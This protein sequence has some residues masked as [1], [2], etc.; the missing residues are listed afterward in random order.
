MNV[1]RHIS[2]G[3]RI[4]ELMR[5]AAVVLGVAVAIGLALPSTIAH[6]A[7]GYDSVT[8]EVP[9][10]VD[11][12]GDA[13]ADAQT[14][15]FVMEPDDGETVSPDQSVVSVDGEGEATFSVS[16]DEVGEHHYTVRQ[17]AG[18]ADGWTYD[19]Q[20]YEVTVY[21]YDMGDQGAD[22]LRTLVIV[23]DGEGY[24]AESCA[25]TNAYE[26]A[27]ENVDEG[28]GGDA[29][30]EDGSTAPAADGSIARTG[31]DNDPGLVMGVLAVGLLAIAVGVVLARRR[32]GR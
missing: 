10:R 1:A 23:E 6:A 9:V 20:A 29:A 27:E 16:L 3:G 13:S 11:V 15:T 18:S 26:A 28:S 21:G 19:A 22:A 5:V 4:R 30:G 32:N 31:D 14:F 25:F 24:K 12:T 17:V 7:S 8:A 2:H